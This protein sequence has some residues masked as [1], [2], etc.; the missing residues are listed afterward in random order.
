MSSIYR[1][2][3]IYSGGETY[4]P[5]NNIYEAIS[6]LKAG[7]N[8]IEYTLSMSLKDNTTITCVYRYNKILKT[9]IAVELSI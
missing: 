2:I 6:F 5:F 7:H 1:D 4:T 9:T 3:R 8:D